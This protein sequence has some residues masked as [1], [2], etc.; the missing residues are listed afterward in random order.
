M[1]IDYR[2]RANRTP[3]FYQMLGPSGWHYIRILPIFALKTDNLRLKT[4]IFKQKGGVLF[5]M[6]F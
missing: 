4:G 6:V 3:A 2:S 1:P 5:K